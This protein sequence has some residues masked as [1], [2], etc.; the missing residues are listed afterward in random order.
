MHVY[1]LCPSLGAYAHVQNPE[2]YSVGA[3]P[4]IYMASRALQRAGLVNGY[5][6]T[7]DSFIRNVRSCLRRSQAEF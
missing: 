1:G 4:H 5:N 2:R 3:A 7:I 6:G